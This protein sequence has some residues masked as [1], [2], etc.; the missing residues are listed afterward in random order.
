MSKALYFILGAGVGAAGAYFYLREKFQ[1]IADEEIESVKTAYANKLDELMGDKELT[2]DELE[3]GK[4]EYGFTPVKLKNSK[5]DLMEFSKMVKKEGYTS[6][7]T[8]VESPGDPVHKPFKD[9]PYEIGSDEE[10]LPN[11]ERKTIIFYSDNV[12]AYEE[13]D[14]VFEYADERLTDDFADRLKETDEIHIRNDIEKTDYTICK[15][16][17]TYKEVTGNDPPEEETEE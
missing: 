5:P 17:R 2:E 11:Y 1:Q 13:D 14:S 7:A 10:A 3:V 16:D 9:E 15:D 4:E 6:Y 12:L 8:K